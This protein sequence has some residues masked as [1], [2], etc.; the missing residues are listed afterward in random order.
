VLPL[1]N[2]LARKVRTAI[3]VL[4]V[5]VG[6]AL[7][8]VLVG[9][10]SMLHEI[11]DR[12]TNVDAHIMVMP[13]SGPALLLGGGLPADKTEARLRAI[14]GVREAIPVLCWSLNMA[15]RDQNAFGIRPEDW[16]FF[17]GPDRL[18]EGRPL[19]GAFEMLIDTRLQQAGG[20]RLGQEIERLNHTFTIVGIAREGVAGRVFI[21]ID[22]LNECLQQDTRRATFFY[23]KADGPAAVEPVRE[24]V[25]N[26][27]LSAFTLDEYYARLANLLGDM[28]LVIGAVVIVAGFVCFLVILLTVYT[29][30]VERTREIG[31][32]KGIGASRLQ[33]FALILAE[34]GLILAGGII[35][36]FVLTLA[37]RALILHLQPLW[38]IDIAAVRFVHAAVLAAVG[39]LLGA[40]HPALRAARQDPVESLR[41]E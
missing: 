15:G 8:L 18:V 36:G 39:T 35:T 3:S 9:L 21:P 34:A 29:M 26:L 5:G 37:G 10:T 40:L 11:A 38:T 31:I 23:V 13:A 17:A 32:L 12:T 27:K 4:A 20:F 2:I 28:H 6:V 24:A 22:T 19:A 16:K 14:P 7:F 41:Y 30:V 25:T 1:A 33:I